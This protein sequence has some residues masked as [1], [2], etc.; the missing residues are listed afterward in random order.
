MLQM[1][2][3]YRRNWDGFIP[4]ILLVL[5]GVVTSISDVDSVIEFLAERSGTGKM[6]KTVV[7]DYPL[8][9]PLIVAV[10]TIGFVRWRLG[11]DRDKAITQFGEEWIKI[12]KKR[13][14]LRRMVKSA[15]EV[16]RKNN[17]NF[18]SAIELSKKVSIPVDLITLPKDL[19]GYICWPSKAGMVR[20]T[21]RAIEFLCCSLS[22]AWGIISA[23]SG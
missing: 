7:T 15:F 17:S 8:F 21:T 3:F 6:L 16:W 10:W 22:R 2:S 12:K 23:Y 19:S 4:F 11:K 14:E 13:Q 18:S 1:W 5:W 9:F 20:R